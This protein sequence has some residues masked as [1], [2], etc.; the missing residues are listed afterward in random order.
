MRGWLNR[1]LAVPLVLFLRGW[2]LNVF[3]SQLPAAGLRYWYSPPL[4][5]TRSGKRGL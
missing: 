1:W 2:L 5:R 4:S 3:V